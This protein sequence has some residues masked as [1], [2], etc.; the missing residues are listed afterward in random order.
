[1]EADVKIFRRNRMGRRLRFCKVIFRSLTAFLRPRRR[2][3]LSA[4]PFFVTSLAIS[5]GGGIKSK[6]ENKT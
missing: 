4:C 1:M 5:N 2:F 3:T 6:I